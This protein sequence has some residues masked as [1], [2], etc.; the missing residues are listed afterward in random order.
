MAHSLFGGKTTGSAEV[1]LC[2]APAVDLSV[3]SHTH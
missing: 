1:A 3:M 2:D